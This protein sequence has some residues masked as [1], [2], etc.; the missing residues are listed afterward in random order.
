MNCASGQPAMPSS[1]G[2]ASSAAVDDSLTL[3]MMSQQAAVQYL[4]RQ[5][6]QQQAQYSQHSM[7]SFAL[8]ARMGCSAGTA[9]LPNTTM[10]PM[11]GG[12]LLYTAQ[13]QWQLPTASQQYILQSRRSQQQ[14]QQ[15]LAGLQLTGVTAAQLPPAAAAAARAVP[16]TTQGLHG[17]WT[18]VWQ[19]SE[20]GTTAAG[21][22][23]QASLAM[24]AGP[25]GQ[26]A[27]LSNSVGQP[28][29]M[30]LHKE[31][32][33]LLLQ[34]Q[35]QRQGLRAAGEALAAPLSSQHIHLAAA[36][37]MG[38]ARGLQL[39]LVSGPA[40]K[41]KH[42]AVMLCNMLEGD[43]VSRPAHKRQY[44]S[45]AGTQRPRSDTQQETARARARDSQLLAAAGDSAAAAPAASHNALSLSP[46]GDVAALLGACS[47]DQAAEQLHSMSRQ[48][49]F[50]F[51]AQVVAG[52]SGPATPEP[53]SSN[54]SEGLAG[55]AA[56]PAVSARSDTSAKRLCMAQAGVC[57]S[58]C[59][60]S[61]AARDS[62]DARSVSPVLD[63][64]L[65]PAVQLEAFYSKPMSPAEA[66]AEAAAV[67][68]AIV[69]AAKAAAA[70]R[71]HSSRSCSPCSPA[72]PEPF[73][74]GLNSP[75][76][77]AATV[78]TPPGGTASGAIPVDSTASDAVQGIGGLHS[79]LLLPCLT[80]QAGLQQGAGSG[81]L[82]ELQFSPIAATTKSGTT[83]TP[84]QQQQQQPAMLNGEVLDISGSCIHV[85]MQPLPVSGQEPAVAALEGTLELGCTPSSSQTRRGFDSSLGLGLSL[86]QDEGYVWQ[87][88]STAAW[89]LSDLSDL[90][91]E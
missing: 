51:A 7:T 52:T 37:G 32:Q 33:Q 85:G 54:C 72:S 91:F 45:A 44:C 9:D 11:P 70:E 63:D 75:G 28:P 38:S 27:D 3:A 5:Q 47:S 69:A 30:V 41:R 84:Q 6:Q 26:P 39:Q 31:L 18:D 16:C 66:A 50:A 68:A 59:A 53:C 55:A 89:G 65:L 13:Q 17:H 19:R 76:D 86:M 40:C 25:L 20:G 36:Q 15:Q 1:L 81:G 23:L 22:A 46:Q 48:Q 2:I 12:P 14:Q 8:A 80:P 62:H 87:E 61:G 88:D 77:L 71:V 60:A 29:P 79:T 78:T 24:S 57:S 64:V 43:R 49:L 4:R 35:L 58:C 74:F 42:P 90:G 21:R 10:L 67:A 83:H 34:Q 73:G 56:S 82:T